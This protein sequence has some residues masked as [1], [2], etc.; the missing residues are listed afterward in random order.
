MWFVTYADGH[1]RARDAGQ[2][3]GTGETLFKQCQK[4]GRIVSLSE[5]QYGTLSR[6]GS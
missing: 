4:R 5:Y 3:D 6:W 2:L 1:V